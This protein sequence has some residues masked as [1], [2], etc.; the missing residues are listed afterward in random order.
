MEIRLHKPA[1][2]GALADQVWPLYQEVFGDFESYESWRIDLYDRHAARDGYR[3]VTAVDEPVMSSTDS[4]V[5]SGSAMVGFAWGYIGRR[6]Q[7]WSDLVC[8]SLPSATTEEWV[9][10][11]FELVELAV[12]PAYRGQGVGRAVHDKVLEGVTGRSLLGTNDDLQDPAVRL[13]LSARWRK[14]GVLRPGVQVM[15]RLPA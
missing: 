4:A 15:G 5:G 11:H 6:G 9:G 7:F 14:L 13:Y 1:D 2:A 12:L 8:D 10:G 3:L